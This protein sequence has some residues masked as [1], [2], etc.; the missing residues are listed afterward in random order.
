MR[1]RKDAGRSE[2]TEWD[3]EMRCHTNGVGESKHEE[4]DNYTEYCDMESSH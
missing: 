3:E 4:G 1:V 2:Q